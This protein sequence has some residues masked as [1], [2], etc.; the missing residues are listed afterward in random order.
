[1]DIL[2][3][4]VELN[5]VHDDDSQ[6]LLVVLL[7]VLTFVTGLVDAVSYLKLGHVFVAN[8]TGNVAFL[9][10]AAA[11]MA[12]LSVPAS[13]AAIAAFLIGAT[14]GGRLSVHIGKDRVRFF[15]VALLIELVLVAASWFA[16]IDIADAQ[17]LRYVLIGSLALAMGLQNAAA[18]FLAVPDL[19][20]T[21]LTLTLTGIAA[22]SSVA[23]GGNVRAGRRLMAT[24]AMLFGAA[25]GA[26]ALIHVGVPTVLGLAFALLAFNVLATARHVRA[27]RS[28]VLA[29]ETR[30]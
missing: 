30:P 14:A 8:M 7:F 16:S 12:D 5:A 22:D 9:G 20:T 19:N 25:V 2:S 1:M 29:A 28:A 23:G 3:P 18:R 26:L 27:R 24:L 17:V 6:S 13:L 15:A 4:G 21:V 11:G 10:F